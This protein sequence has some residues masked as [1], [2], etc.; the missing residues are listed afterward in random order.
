MTFYK[1]AIRR[2]GEYN[3]IVELI[4]M[5]SDVPTR[6]KSRREAMAVIKRLAIKEKENGKEVRPRS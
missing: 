5:I 6:I 1:I 4:P 3:E 2:S